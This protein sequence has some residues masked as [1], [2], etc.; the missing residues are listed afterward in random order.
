VITCGGLL[1]WLPI[2]SANGEWTSFIDALFTAT[3]A[4]AVT[5]QVTLNTAAHWNYFGKT[6]II[7]LIEIGGLGFMTLWIVF[8]Y[9]LFKHRPNLRQR[10]I[11]TESLS[12]NAGDSVQK[13]VFAIVRFSLTVQLI[14]A[15]LLGFVFVPEYGVGKGIYYSIFHSISAFC[16]AGFDLIGNSLIDYQSNPFIL[17]VIAS[18]IMAGG[19]GFIVWEDL[20]NYRKVRKLSNY[21]KIVLTV[22]ASLWILG[23]LLFWITEHQNGTFSHLS[24]GD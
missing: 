13:K 2:S 24:F 1:L 5:G 19:L 17:L 11:V 12:L 3:S 23:T 15:T 8:Y 10:R 9:Y 21:S 4:T 16:N 14:G 6:V 7:T 18:L 22:T 20:L